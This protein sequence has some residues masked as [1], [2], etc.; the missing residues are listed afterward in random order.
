MVCSKAAVADDL[1]PAG[2][3]AVAL[4]HL[5]RYLQGGFCMEDFR[6]IHHAYLIVSFFGA[7]TARAG[8]CGEDIFVMAAQTYGEERGKRM[9][10]RAL[11]DGNALD[12][13]SYFAYC[14]WV[15]TP[16][17]SEACFETCP[18]TVVESV[19]RCP[20]NAVFKES[21]SACGE[22]YCREIDRAI[23]RGF[24]PKLRFESVQTLAHA[25][26]CKMRFFDEMVDEAF[27][28]RVDRLKQGAC[29]CVRPFSYH[30]GHLWST[31][32][33]IALNVL[34]D[35]AGGQAVRQA[36][37]SFAGRFGEAAARALVQYA[38]EP[39]FSIADHQAKIPENR[40]MQAVF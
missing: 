26:S 22:R 11:R 20:W 40:E 2:K 21:G 12:L 9:A 32:S 1:H 6:E 36:Y 34:G 23:V 17:E 10:M 37:D 16:G 18:G 13:A 4:A 28:R 25:Q 3:K 14:E 38:H 7:L 8:A 15:P 39:F 33:R 5:R 30:C 27:W 29:S 31:F 24:S 35:E 19:V